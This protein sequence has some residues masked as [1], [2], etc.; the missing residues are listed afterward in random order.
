MLSVQKD[1][2][3]FEL[4]V[5]LTTNDIPIDLAKEVARN[6]SNEKKAA[7]KEKAKNRMYIGAILLL[8]TFLIG[9]GTYWFTGRVIFI[10][11]VGIVAGLAYLA[12]GIWEYLE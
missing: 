1:L 6:M 9:A 10:M 4:T 5:K 2:S 8:L 11:G 3:E 7:S 12:A